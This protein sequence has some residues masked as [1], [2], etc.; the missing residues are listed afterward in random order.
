MRNL[1]R[2]L[3]ILLVLLLTTVWAGYL[4]I[5]NMPERID[6]L[7]Q[8]VLRGDW[9]GLTGVILAIPPGPTAHHFYWYFGLPV[10][11]VAGLVIGIRCSGAVTGEREKQTWEALLL[12]PLETRQLIRGKFW[13]ICGATWPYLLAYTIPA[14]LLSWV[15]G[16]GAFLWT[17]LWLGVTLL[18]MAFVGAAGDVVFGP[19]AE[20][21]AQFAEYARVRL[22]R[23]LFIILFHQSSGANPLTHHHLNPG[24]C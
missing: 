23:R 17:L 19:V 11:L 13:G 18:A 1:P 16:L 2:W 7:W 24:A 10:M 8:R 9:D 21:L 4:L 15:G 5:I 20:F 14:L 6:S 12:T 22:R 3:G